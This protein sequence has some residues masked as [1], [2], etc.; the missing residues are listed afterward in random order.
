LFGAGCVCT[1][2]VSSAV[3]VTSTLSPTT[4][5]PVFAPQRM[6]LHRTLSPVPMFSW[7]LTVAPTGIWNVVFS[8]RCRFVVE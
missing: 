2:H 3:R 7:R 4:D 5:D 1:C 8:T 6:P